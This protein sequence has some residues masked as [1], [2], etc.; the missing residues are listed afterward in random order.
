MALTVYCWLLCF[1]PA[2]YRHEFGEE[3]TSVF[4]EARSE[5]PPGLVVK[6]SFYGREFSGL[7]SGALRAHF[8]RLFGP[9]THFRRFAMQSQF[10]FSRSTVL[11]MLVIFAAVI[12]TIAKAMSVSVTYGATPGTVWPSLISVFGAMAV[13]MCAAAAVIWG[14]LHSLRRSGVHRL[15]N[16]QSWSGSAKSNGI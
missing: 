9:V 4:R 6:S 11:L 12:L 14:I 10:R 16:V 3:M 2:S 15:E 13:S 1:Y 7:L 5:L 8:D